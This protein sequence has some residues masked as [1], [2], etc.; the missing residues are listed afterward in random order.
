M[1]FYKRRV[2]RK[3]NNCPVEELECRRLLTGLATLASFG[4]QGQPRTPST[5][6]VM[7]NGGNLF[8]RNVWRT[9]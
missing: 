9:K 7:D 2:K 8:G 1:S 5:S 6:L 4:P 3:I